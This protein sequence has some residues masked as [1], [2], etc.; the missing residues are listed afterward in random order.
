MVRFF[1]FYN[2]QKVDQREPGPVAGLDFFNP[3]VIKQSLRRAI[4]NPL[5]T[6]YNNFPPWGFF[7]KSFQKTQGR[8]MFVEITPAGG[9]KTFL[10]KLLNI[11]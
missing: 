10:Q 3:G 1:I 5:K 2:I 6:F 7:R 9:Y 8:E 4:Q 11:F